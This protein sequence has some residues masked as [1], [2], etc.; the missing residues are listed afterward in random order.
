VEP[1]VRDQD[2]KKAIEVIIDAAQTGEI[3]DGKIFVSPVVEVIRVRAGERGETAWSPGDTYPSTSMPAL[4]DLP[5]SQIRKV[6]R[7][8][9]G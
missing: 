6:R 3:G 4:L 7:C 1:V 9:D 2:T 8:S 5:K